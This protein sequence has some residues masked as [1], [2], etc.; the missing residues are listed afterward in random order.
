MQ[1]SDFMDKIAQFPHLKDISLPR[2]PISLKSLIDITGPSLKTSNFVEQY[3]GLP[4]GLAMN[5]VH[6]NGENGIV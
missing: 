5:S 2:Q 4:N 6:T 3:S 1:L